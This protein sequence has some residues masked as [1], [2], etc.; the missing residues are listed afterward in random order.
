MV[1]KGVVRCVLV[2]DV[3]GEM[4]QLR[5]RRLM[6]LRSWHSNNRQCFKD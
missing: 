3:M 1:G 5:M 6:D 4:C 2:E